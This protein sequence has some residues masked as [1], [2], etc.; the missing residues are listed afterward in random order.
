M[1]F[2]FVKILQ[3]KIYYEYLIIREE[4]LAELYEYESK[5]LSLI[6][7]NCIQQRFNDK[8]DT[9]TH[10]VEHYI[11]DE[12]NKVIKSY[13][14]TKLFNRPNV[15]KTLLTKPIDSPKAEVPIEDIQEY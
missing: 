10:S 14:L 13:T 11:Y 4:I 9:T 5:I 12:S 3:S 2:W 15:A 6:V 7:K 8:N 1:G